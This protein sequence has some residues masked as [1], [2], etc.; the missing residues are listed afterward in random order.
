MVASSLWQRLGFFNLYAMAKVFG[1]LKRCR[2]VWVSRGNR[3]DKRGHRTVLQWFDVWCVLQLP[4]WTHNINVN[5][6]Y[7]HL[8]R[9]LLVAVIW[10]FVTRSAVRMV[11]YI[12]N[13]GTWDFLPNEMRWSV[14]PG[15]KESVAFHQAVYQRLFVAIVAS[16][17][18]KYRSGKN[19][20]RMNGVGGCNF[21]E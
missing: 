11:I 14:R 4:G 10:I 19:I 7:L 1:S 2:G 8:L 12:C 6:L 20:R 15:N 13:A 5:F 17:D 21:F 3:I 18:A 9:L 16:I